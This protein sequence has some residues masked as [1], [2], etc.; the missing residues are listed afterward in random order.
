MNRSDQDRIK[1]LTSPYS[2][3]QP[4]QLSL[5]FSDYLSLLWR[6]DRH[7]T[8]V[9]LVK[10]YTQCS[11]A[12]SKAFGFDKK[13]LGRVARSAEPGEIYLALSNVPFRDTRR[14]ADA[15]ARKAAVLQLVL[16]RADVLSIGSYQH[17]WLVGWPGSG[18]LDEELREHVFAT[19]FTALRGQ[20]VHFGRLLLVIDI[21][22]QE[23]LLGER[24]LTEISLGRLIDRYGFPDP[25]D[26]AVRE[27]FG[28]DSNKWR[29]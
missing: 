27:L 14:L 12:L 26:A 5:D 9:N 13:N 8:Q 29:Y 18:M 16:L 4:P 20:Y 21:V 24:D 3:F 23:L 25:E 15:S 7:Y 1:Q 11:R 2:P 28:T 6:V 22:L 10:Y 19:L 17:E